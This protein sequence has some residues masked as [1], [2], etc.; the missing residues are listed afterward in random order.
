MGRGPMSRRYV[1][2]GKRGVPLGQLQD[3]LVA[4]FEE[5]DGEPIDRFTIAAKLY[6]GI[7]EKT[8]LNRVNMVLY[9]LRN[10]IGDALVNDWARGY[11]LAPGT[12]VGT[13]GEG[14]KERAEKAREASVNTQEPSEPR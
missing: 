6:P 14:Y 3:R 9:D 4:L 2:L 10:K 11:R 5:A 7:A 13:Y 8:A 1:V 12:R